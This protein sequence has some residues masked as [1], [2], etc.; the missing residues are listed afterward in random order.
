M[1]LSSE[2]KSIQVEARILWAKKTWTKTTTSHS[3][4]QAYD[5]TFS[6][7]DTLT[8]FQTTSKAVDAPSYFEIRELSARNV[9]GG[10]DLDQRVLEALRNI[11]LGISDGQV[12][13]S[14]DQCQRIWSS[15][16]VV[17]LM[18][19]PYSG[20]RDYVSATSQPL[21]FVLGL[22]L[23]ACSALIFFSARVCGVHLCKFPRFH[24]LLVLTPFCPVLRVPWHVA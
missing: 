9:A 21:R 19:L 8:N 18:F 24:L 6:G 20:L 16:L 3:A 5:I 22:A 1:D 7:F 11:G 10:M 23:C 17:E 14:E 13:V 12:D 15:G 4:S 2:M